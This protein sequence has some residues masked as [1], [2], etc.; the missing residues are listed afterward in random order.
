MSPAVGRGPN[1]SQ[2]TGERA[3]KGTRGRNLRGL[4]ALLRP[5]RL[6]ATLTVVA[7]L[8]GTAAS[9]APPL[10]ARAA[11]DD[12]IER[13]DFNK[14]VLVVVAFFAAALIVWRASS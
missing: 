12:G 9:L 13:H 4:F 11:I 6:R 10:L 1:Q 5:Y 14:L 7:L 3:S 8:L 2:W